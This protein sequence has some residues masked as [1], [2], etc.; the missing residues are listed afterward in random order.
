MYNF[1]SVGGGI[2]SLFLANPSLNEKE[3]ISLTEQ[4]EEK[5]IEILV[6]PELTLTGT[7]CGD[8]FFQPSIINGS[9]IALK[10]ILKSTNDTNIAIFIGIPIS[11][12]SRLYNCMALIFNGEV[13]AFIV[14]NPSQNEARWFS[15]SDSICSETINYN[16][17]DV[18]I[19]D[20]FTFIINNAIVELA[21]PDGY[22]LAQVC[23]NPWAVPDNISFNAENKAITLTER[24]TGLLCVSPSSLE[25]TTDS[26]YSG[27]CL[28]TENGIVLNKNKKYCFNSSLT[29][30]QFDLSIIKSQNRFIQNKRII[31]NF[32]SKRE[33]KLYRNISKTP[34]IPSDELKLK[35]AIEIQ[36]ASLARRLIHTSSKSA[37]VGV[38]GGVDSTLALLATVEAFK[39]LEKPAK[40]IIA[41]TMPGMGTS[42]T[43]YN[44][45][46]KL[47]DIVGVK[48]KEISIVNAVKQ[49]FSDIGHDINKKD[50][51]Y[52]NA[53]ARERTQILMDLANMENGIVVG[54]GGLSESALGFATYN[55]DHMSMYNVNGGLP[56]T[57]IIEMLRYIAKTNESISSCI[58][59]ILVTPIS[60][61]LLPT[62]DGIITQKT[63]E[64]VGP[65]MLNDFFIY[66]M[67]KNV[68]PQ[69]ILFL[70][71]NAFPEIKYEEITMRLKNFITRF[72]ASQYKRSC[73]AD[74]PQIIDFS[75]SPR[76]GYTMPSDALPDEWLKCM[77]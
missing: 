25:S 74:G 65:Y 77:Q 23:I 12:D 41:V 51:T 62:A 44:N 57:L 47:V 70:A 35:H 63:E 20:K 15:C 5:R 66:Y 69:K 31:I 26:L 32:S 4:A 13:L 28:I 45:A 7:T 37:I 3:V 46:K 34:F 21:D 52:E 75:L 42:N 38:S 33:F 18:P 29:C 36:A 59:S 27:E 67:I 43:T 11:Y 2:P 30:S 19:G 61:E 54:A 49:H 55:G 53:Q 60:P 24:G 64:V 14:K 48:L 50:T 68:P 71:Q 40:D 1:I 9:D 76:G 17:K 10:N 6:F 39:K 73:S 22:S 16:G 56:K 72:F 8:L 58:E